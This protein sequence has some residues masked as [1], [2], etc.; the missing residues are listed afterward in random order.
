MRQPRQNLFPDASADRLAWLAAT[1]GLDIGPEELAALAKQLRALETLERDEL[2]DYPPI[3]RM[4][5]G[6]HD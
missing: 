6:W 1:L 3:L 4:D 2:Q 5:A